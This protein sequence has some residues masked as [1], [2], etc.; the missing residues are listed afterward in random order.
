MRTLHFCLFS[1][2]LALSARM[3]RRGRETLDDPTAR[4]ALFREACNLAARAGGVR[5][6][7]QAIEAMDQHYVVELMDLKV[8]AMADL[9]PSVRRPDAWRQLALE[10][11]ALLG[12]ALAGD[13]HSTATRL[14]PGARSAVGLARS[15]VLAAYL[16]STMK[17]AA[18][19]KK[20]YRAMPGAINTL[21]ENPDDPRAN[22]ALG[23]YRC[24]VKDNWKEGLRHL[25]KSGNRVFET[26][27]E[28]GDTGVFSNN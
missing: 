28:N 21:A 11:L 7:L 6:T 26:K 22:L 10:Y 8:E 15:Q 24:L 23:R 25:E 27:E 9:L 3:L 20:E 4:L 1:T 19:L 12:K 17:D 13:M 16:E 14:L 5:E 2:A 18:F